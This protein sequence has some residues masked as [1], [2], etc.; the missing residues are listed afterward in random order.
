MSIPKIIFIVPYRNRKY[1]KIHFSI[2]MKYLLEDYN[3]NDYKIYYSFQ[4]DER[5]FNRGATKNIGFLALKNKYPDDYKNFT[6]VFNDIDT[7]PYQKNF[8]DYE[9]KKGVIKHFYGFTYALGGIFSINGEDFEKL[10]GFPNNWGWGFEDN[11]INDRAVKNNIIINRNVFFP[12]NSEK[13]LQINTEF[14]RKINNNENIN[15]FKKNLNETFNNI[16]NLDYTI[17]NENNNEYLIIIN[18]FI[19]TNNPYNSKYFDHD[20]RTGSKIKVDLAKYKNV[21]RKWKMF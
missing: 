7:L 19:T 18:N 5:P 4:N 3:T 16:Y 11:E 6:F 2:Y 1:Q 21:D 14:F 13:I 12:I 17:I 15:Y 8:L 9:T 20:L 10:G